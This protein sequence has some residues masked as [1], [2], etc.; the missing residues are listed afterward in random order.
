M[1]EF[2]S[3]YV[4]VAKKYNPQTL[5]ALQPYWHI[6]PPASNF[7]VDPVSVKLQMPFKNLVE[8]DTAS[9]SGKVYILDVVVTPLLIVC[10]PIDMHAHI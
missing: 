4:L 9:G 10:S 6:K 3:N 8:V 2:I 5:P 7:T 1:R